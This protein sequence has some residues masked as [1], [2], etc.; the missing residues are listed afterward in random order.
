VVKTGAKV[1]VRSLVVGAYPRELEL[2][3]IARALVVDDVVPVARNRGERGVRISDPAEEIDVV[4]RVRLANE[5]TARR[6]LCRRRAVQQQAD[7]E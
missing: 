2:D 5:G 1:P 7:L 3:R 6:E 4:D